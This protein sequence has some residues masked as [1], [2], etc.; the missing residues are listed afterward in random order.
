[1]T[2]VH[3]A[4]GVGAVLATLATGVLGAWAWRGGVSRAFW[5]AARTGQVLIGV[6]VLLGLLLLMISSRPHV[7]MHP[8][9]GLGALVAVIVTEVARVR[10]GDTALEGLRYGDRRRREERCE[11]IRPGAMDMARAALA[12][13]RATTIGSV[14]VF[15]LVLAAAAS[16]G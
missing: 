10:A 3:L 8:A 16:G 14:V 4:V 7:A 11:P 6:Q 12:E 15:A 5:I 9:Y 2:Y 1:M 13:L